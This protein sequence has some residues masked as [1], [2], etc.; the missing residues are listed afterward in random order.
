MIDTICKVLFYL[1]CALER[2][3]DGRVDMFSMI[4]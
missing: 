4:R 2:P 3:A 1:Q